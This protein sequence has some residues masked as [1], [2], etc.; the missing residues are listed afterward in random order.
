M[1]L[2]GTTVDVDAVGYTLDATHTLEIT[3]A[4]GGRARLP[5]TV[6][7][8]QVSTTLDQPAFDALGVGK[9]TVTV[10]IR[11]RN[12]WGE[13]LGEPTVVS[14]E[15]VEALAPSV[16]AV[17][18]GL[19][20]LNDPVVVEGRGL[21]LGGA[22][23]RTEVELAGCFLPEGQ[24]TPCATHGKK[25]VITVALSP[26]DVSRERGSFAYPAKLA[27]LS[28]G[29]FS[30][31]LALV[32]Y[33]TGRA[34]TRSSERQID[35]EVQRTTLTGLKS[36]A[37]SL[38][39]YLLIRGRGFVGG[40]GSTLL[41][42]DGT[43]QPSGEGTSRAVKLS[44][45]TGFVNGQTLRYVLEEKNGLGASVDLR[46]ETGT[47]SGT[48]TPVVSL[49]AEQQV[50]KGVVLALE[51]G[52]VKQVVHLRF[53]PSWQEALRSFGLQPADQR[54]RDRVFAVVRRAYQ[55][56]N[57]EI[58]AE[59]PKDFGLY[60]TVDVGGTDPNGLGLL[61]YDNT[62][63]KDVEN[64]RLFD[65][66][67]GVNA[68]TQEDGYPGYGG[69]FASS[70]LAFS[71]HPPGAM[72]TSPLHTPLFDQI[73]D[74]VRPDR[75]QEVNSAEVAAAPSLESSASCPAADRV[76]QVACA[77]FTL[78]NMI[79]HT[80]A[81][82]LG[83]SFGLA[84]PYGAPTTY[85]NP[86]DVPNR[87]ME[88]G[89]TRPFAERAELAGEGPAVFCDDEF[90]YLQMLMPTGQADPLPQRPSCY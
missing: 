59:Q 37:V 17:G 21:L 34:P 65:H 84:E 69:V 41:E 64:K 27:G 66:V 2:V 31:T 83:H 22:E 46:S 13:T 16:K 38:G 73:F 11:S 24:P 50:G 5:L 6:A 81:H 63:G 85:H 12:S 28:P 57:V 76:G 71:E 20:H 86:G 68:L 78:G 90:A 3:T 15:L 36:S 49:G 56:I 14:L 80:V 8:G 10:Q 47:L 25:A 70:Q 9:Q 52:A 18:D 30:G 53:L 58:R 40:E 48:W 29:R 7:D 32:N 67:G 4:G 55:G 87:L 43:F 45:V 61:G 79:G 77:I 89:S 42:V 23:G 51:L 60:A 44:F 33:Q 26:V 54:V 75:G 19:V 88:G 1:L 82:E 72:K 35:F 62:P 39:E 74:A